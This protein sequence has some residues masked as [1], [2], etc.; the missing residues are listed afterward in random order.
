MHHGRP[1]KQCMPTAMPPAD[2]IFSEYLTK[3]G[4]S[5][6]F[7]SVIWSIAEDYASKWD[8]PLT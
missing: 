8:G 4:S 1:S 6:E 3:A 5:S 2:F 7:R